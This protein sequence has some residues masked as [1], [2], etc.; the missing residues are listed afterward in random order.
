MTDF[1]DWQQAAAAN[2][3][4]QF[5]S[6]TQTLTPGDHP[7]TITPV[8]SWSSL[9]L[10]VNA[11]A[12]AAKVSV[13]HYADLAG[14]E[15]VDTD[16]WTCNATAPLTVRVPLRA[17]YAQLDINVTSAVDLQSDTYAIYST[18]P[19][20]RISFP[21]GAQ[22]VFIPQTTLA[23]GATVAYDM[24]AIASGTAY[25]SYVP[26]DTSGNINVYLQIVDELDNFLTIITD[27][28]TP[29]TIDNALIAVPDALVQ[30]V[31]S[32]NDAAATHDYAFSLMIPPQ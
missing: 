24:P 1:P 27:R 20:D 12:G 11:T 25:W 31:V 2:A 19:A 14:T 10:R 30:I 18:Y 16:T 32:N 21:I 8:A 3:G 22:Q 29:T 6:F 23:I 4:N 5:T 15:L 17:H 9:T 28:G 7:G 26:Y 13:R